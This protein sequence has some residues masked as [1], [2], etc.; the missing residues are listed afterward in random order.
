MPATGE[1]W[2]QFTLLEPLGKGGMGE[3]FLADDTSLRPH[4]TTL[5]HEL[6][7]LPARGGVED[8]VVAA[9]SQELGVHFEPGPLT[10]EE[11]AREQSTAASFLVSG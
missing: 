9:F 10:A 5:N 4:I 1:T 2:N 6:V 11:T 3:V 7:E 8:A